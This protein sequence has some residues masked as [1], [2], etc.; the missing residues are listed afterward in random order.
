MV[1]GGWP[2]WLLCQPQSKKLGFGDFQTYSQTY[3]SG[4]GDCWEGGLGLG[5]ASL[6]IRKGSMMRRFEF[7]GLEANK[8]WNLI[9]VI[10]KSVFPQK[11]NQQWIYALNEKVNVN[12]KSMRQSIYHASNS[13][14][15]TWRSIWPCRFTSLGMIQTRK[16]SIFIFLVDKS[17]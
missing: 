12:D 4:L 10:H 2:M 16:K 8:D 1:P 13:L 5:L 17:M 15:D 11:I 3:C 9:E 7:P 14:R 6:T